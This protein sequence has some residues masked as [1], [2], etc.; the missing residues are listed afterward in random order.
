[1]R[2]VVRVLL[3]FSLGRAT[4]DKRDGFPQESVIRLSEPELTLARHGDGPDPRLVEL[5]RLLARQ[6]AREWYHHLAEERRS[7]RS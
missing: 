1:M 5:V 2:M 4:M 7:K 3:Q 6:A